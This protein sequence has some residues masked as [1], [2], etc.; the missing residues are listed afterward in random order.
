L[1]QWKKFE[2]TSIVDVDD[3]VAKE[4]KTNDVKYDE[5]VKNESLDEK[6]GDTKNVP[7]TDLPLE[8]LPNLVVTTKKVGQLKQWLQN[9]QSEHCRILTVFC[10]RQEDKNSHMYTPEEQGVNVFKSSQL[11]GLVKACEPISFVILEKEDMNLMDVKEYLAAETNLPDLQV[12]WN[13]EQRFVLTQLT[14]CLLMKLYSISGEILK[15]LRTR[16]PSDPCAEQ[17]RLLQKSFHAVCKREVIAKDDEGGNFI[18]SP[19]QQEI[20]IYCN[21][22]CNVAT[23]LKLKA[24]METFENK[25][26]YGAWELFKTTP[27]VAL[28]FKTLLM[29]LTEREVNALY[30]DMT[31]NSNRVLFD[32]PPEVSLY[33]RAR[34]H[35]LQFIIWMDANSLMDCVKNWLMVEHRKTDLLT[36]CN[37]YQCC[38]FQWIKMGRRPKPPKHT[39]FTYVLPPVRKEKTCSTSLS[40]EGG[41]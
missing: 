17:A 11:S 40:G 22:L 19:S 12:T 30:P 34:N 6:H 2:S 29:Q 24:W 20:A 7:T 8:A 23:I 14:R 25:V 18:R 35:V 28:Q 16:D 27:T 41:G 39:C 36:Y 38:V 3:A 21:V 31:T 5:E 9:R 13:S 15:H 32:I 37:F 4:D 10:S 26:W 33:F 1:V